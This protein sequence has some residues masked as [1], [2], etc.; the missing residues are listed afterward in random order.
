[1]AN[2]G[3]ELPA[4]SGP[5]HRLNNARDGSVHRGV[6]VE[7]TY[8]AHHFGSV[9]IAAGASRRPPTTARRGREASEQIA[10]RPIGV[11]GGAQL[12]AN[13]RE[14]LAD[15]VSRRGDIGGLAGL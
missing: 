6:L 1:M 3:R 7:V 15:L 8:A 10:H 14:I 11:L 2:S 5:H 4:D 12:A 13:V 9:A